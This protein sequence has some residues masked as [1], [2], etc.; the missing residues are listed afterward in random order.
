[1]ELTITESLGSDGH[2][3][4]SLEIESWDRLKTLIG[5]SFYILQYLIYYNCVNA[6]GH[7]LLTKRKS[8]IA[9]F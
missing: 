3:L 6:L 5:A 7:H 1:M 4:K 2:Y 9:D 8:K